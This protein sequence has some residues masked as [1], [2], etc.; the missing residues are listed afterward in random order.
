MENL[1]I[2]LADSG[3]CSLIW[4]PLTLVGIGLNSPR[5]SAGA[6]GLRS[7]VS[8][9]LGPPPFQIRMTEVS[10]VA[11]PFAA[12]SARSAQHVGERQAGEAEE[13]RLEEAAAADAVAGAIGGCR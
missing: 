6:S 13:A 11:L 7:Q 1:S 3:R 2:C 5:Y 8:R 12:C 9:W 4:M 10:L